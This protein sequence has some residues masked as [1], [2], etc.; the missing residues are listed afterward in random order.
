MA[1]DHHRAAREA[2]DAAENGLVLGERAVAGERREV[3][4]QTIDVVTEVRTLG[5]AGDLR[6]LPGRELRVGLFQ[7][8]L[9]F[10]FELG[11][12]LLDRHGALLGRERLQLGD[13]AFEL[14][15]RFFE[16]EIG[17][18]PALAWPLGKA[19]SPA[20]FRKRNKARGIWL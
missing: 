10:A 17:A 15:D 5:V 1:D 3:L 2:P 19:F 16:I 7:G 18:H 14:G 13:L 4:H 11:K 12:L 9:G 8:L 20:D 6:L